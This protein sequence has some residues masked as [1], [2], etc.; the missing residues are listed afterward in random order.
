ME[1]CPV[2]GF[3]VSVVEFFS[4]TISDLVTLFVIVTLCAGI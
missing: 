4:P 1:S 2:T 3:G